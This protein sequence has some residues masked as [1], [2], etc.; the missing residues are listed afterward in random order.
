MA[1]KAIGRRI[2]AVRQHAGFSQEDL[3]DALGV[4]RS[5]VSLWEKGGVL[6]T[7]AHMQD[8]AGVLQTT[9]SYLVAGAGSPPPVPALPRHRYR[10]NIMERM[11]RLLATGRFDDLLG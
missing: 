2:R 8:L 11:Q 4:T 10:R 7:D 1:S 6:P 9:V 3:G 5:A